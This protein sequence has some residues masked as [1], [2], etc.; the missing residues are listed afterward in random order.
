LVEQILEGE[1]A[2]LFEMELS[3]RKAERNKLLRFI[4][5]PAGADLEK[6]PKKEPLLIP[7]QSLRL[8]SVS[9]NDHD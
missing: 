4:N 7:P 3:Q 9:S 8:S 1:K 5:N 6:D 2:V